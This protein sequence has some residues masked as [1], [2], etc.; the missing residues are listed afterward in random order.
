MKVSIVIPTYRGAR[1]L[2]RLI[3][4]LPCD[5]NSDVTVVDDGSPEADRRLAERVLG[6][7]SVCMARF[8][9][10]PR[11]GWTAALNT[12]VP[13]T[14]GEIV[15]LLDDD[16]LLPPDLLPT[17]RG[18]FL[19]LDN[20]GVLSWRSLG[21]KPGQ[22]QTPRP[23]H[24]QPATQLAGFCYAF[25]RSLWDELGGLDPRFRVYCADSDFALRATLAGHPSYRV[26]WP[27]VPHL[28]HAAF[29]EAPELGDRGQIAAADLNLFRLKWGATGAEMEARALRQLGEER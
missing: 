3:R 2:E 10:A 7:S 20:V 25:R 26:W 18:L 9:A 17:L 21:D 8:V 4:G 28:E 24:L 11:A 19:A 23:G 29:D 5:I 22:S 27:L 13:G 14:V 6:A 1:R 15:L 16:T 12:A